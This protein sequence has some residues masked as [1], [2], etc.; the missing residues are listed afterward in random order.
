MIMDMV[1]LIGTILL[2]EDLDTANEQAIIQGLRPLC[3]NRT[4]LLITHQPSLPEIADAI[5]EI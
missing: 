1:A 5:L 3:R 4:V 2:S